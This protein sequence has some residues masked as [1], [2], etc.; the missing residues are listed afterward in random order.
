MDNEDESV[1]VAYIGM[2]VFPLVFGLLFYLTKYVF[3]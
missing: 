1:K 2:V 3:M